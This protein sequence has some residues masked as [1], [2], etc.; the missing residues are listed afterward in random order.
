MYVFAK[1]KLINLIINDA[2]QFL[3]HQPPHKLNQNS[4][5]KFYLVGISKL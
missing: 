4:Q 5:R 1:F 3:N 2:A